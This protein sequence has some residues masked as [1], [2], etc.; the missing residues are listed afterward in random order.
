MP[1][2]LFRPLDDDPDRRPHALA[3]EALGDGGT[4]L[5]VGCGAGAGSLLL[6]PPAVELV[7]VDPSAQMLSTERGIPVRVTHG[8]WPDVAAQV[9]PADVVVCRHVLYNV[10]DLVPFARALTAHARRRVVV[11]LAERHPWV[12]IGPL[13]QRFHGQPGPTGPTAELAA[14]VLAEGGV[15]VRVEHAPDGPW[16]ELEPAQRVAMVRRQLCLPPDRDA[17]VATALA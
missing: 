5:D 6:A 2:E 17:D 8:R 10:P 9:P 15:D 7:G 11:E 14:Q 12:A 16:P 4:V 13:W 3:R 1:A